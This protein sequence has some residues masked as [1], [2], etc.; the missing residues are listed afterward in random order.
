MQSATSSMSRMF[1]RAAW[2]AACALLV[3]CGGSEDN[4]NPSSSGGQGASTGGATGSGGN[5]GAVATGGTAGSSSGGSANLGGMNSGSGGA[6]L[7][8]YPAGPYDDALGMVLPNLMWQGYVNDRDW[9]PASAEPLSLYS[10]DD[11]RQSGKRYALVHAS[12]VF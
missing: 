11:V 1:R 3:S 7:G 6:D 9:G 8:S 5:A 4:G 10:L 2:T 12:A